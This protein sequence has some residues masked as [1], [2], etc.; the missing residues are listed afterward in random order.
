MKIENEKYIITIVCIALVL[1]TT[2]MCSTKLLTFC[3]CRKIKTH[4]TP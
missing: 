3:L 2:Q 4:T 1:L